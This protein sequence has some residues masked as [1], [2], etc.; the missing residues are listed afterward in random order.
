M[1][2]VGWLLTLPLVAFAATRDDYASQWPLALQDAD[3]GAYRVVLDR[4]VY[5]QLQSPRLQDLVVVNAQ[6][7]P[8]ATA[9][10]PAD[11]PLA[12]A[13]A[14]VAVP[15]FPLPI[16]T[17]GR[18]RDIAAISEIATDGSLRRVELRGPANATATGDGGFV[19]DA[20]QLHGAVAALHV[21]WSDAA[22]FDRGY[23][24]SASDD[25]R[26]WRDVD[27]DA[28]LVQLLNNGQRIVE[29]RIALP[30]VQARYLRLLPQ[31]PQAV[32]LQL[33]GVTAALVGQVDVPALQWEALHGRRVDTPTGPAF[34]YVLDGRF[35][36]E[37]A[38]VV[39]PGNS[40]RGWTLESRDDDASAWRAA[41]SPWV[42][43]RIDSRGSS[44][45]SAPQRL[46]DGSRHRHWRLRAREPFE[47]PVPVLR[48]GYRPEV[49]VFLA[50]GSAPFSLLAGSARTSRRDA[51]LP[52]LVE[53]LR[54]ERGRDWQPATATLGARQTLAGEAALEPVVPPTDWKRWLLW[55][56]LVAGALLVA[57]FAFSLLRQPRTPS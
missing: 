14:R 13:G 57:A 38:D 51:P 40:T 11:A 15:W 16:E 28:R 27:A 33:T 10:F 20:S 5:R 29:D 24:V 49:V 43:Y 35:P 50:E 3:G 32:A 30:A 6:G 47:G 8:V 9:V 1:K 19:I 52:Q 41:A 54:A 25:L 55:G 37:A 4:G 17:D 7:A 44:S 23:R 26:Q 39:S 31:S 18:A 2:K 56:V 21:R 46:H 36:V 22:A 48:L 45:Q 12:Q 42:A 53:A 34:D